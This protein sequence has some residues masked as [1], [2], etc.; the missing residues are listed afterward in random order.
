MSTAD[1]DF[2]LNEMT[3]I[4]VHLT[5]GQVDQL[6]HY[7]LMLIETNKVMNLTAI[8]EYE[9][10]VRKHFVDSLSLVRDV[11]MGQCKKVMDVGTGAGFPGIPLKIVFPN[12]QITLLDSLGKR[13]K[14]LENVVNDLGLSDVEPI[15]GRAEDIA[16]EK[17]YRE[18]YDLCTSRAVARLSVL[19]EYC[20]PFVKVGGCFASYKAGE[21]EEEIKNAAR[22]IKVLGGK[23]EKTDTFEIDGMGR[24]IILIRKAK[25]TSPLYPR[26]A[27]T[28][29]K[30]PIL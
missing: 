18:Q 20:L 4:G 7:Y 19:S 12:L 24:S 15:H 8:T 5:D 16:R 28:P 17:K 21:C 26:K 1:R 25:T 13:V 6:I 30:K 27:G 23:M 29:A 2:L 11:D 10:V 3:K 9:E 14:F 22:A